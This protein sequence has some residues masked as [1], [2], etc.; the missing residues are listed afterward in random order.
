MSNST[1]RNDRQIEEQY[2]LP[3]LL[4]GHQAQA[5]R[6]SRFYATP[7]SNAPTYETMQ[8]FHYGLRDQTV[9][10][11]P[12]RDSSSALAA[13]NSGTQVNRPPRQPFPDGTRSY[14]EYSHSFNQTDSRHGLRGYANPTPSQFLNGNQVSAGHGGFYDSD[15]AQSDGPSIRVQR[16]VNTNYNTETAHPPHGY[17]LGGVNAV[18][19][20]GSAANTEAAIGNRRNR[21]VYFCNVP[22]CTSQGFTQRHNYEY[23]IRSHMD[24]RPFVCDDCERGFNSRSDLNRHIRRVHEA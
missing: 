20:V 9:E 19:P 12:S 10:P 7:S 23:H 24:D 13:P 18:R 14:P 11:P 17:E 15:P 6:L 5:H 4:A 2:E 3:Y 1:S 8:T 22:G 16:P 21:P